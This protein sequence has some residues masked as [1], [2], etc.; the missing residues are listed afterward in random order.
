MSELAN[1]FADAYAADLDNL[2]LIVHELIRIRD[3]RQ[4]KEMQ[5]PSTTGATSGVHIEHA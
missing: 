4:R 5:E 3:E 2:D 1:L